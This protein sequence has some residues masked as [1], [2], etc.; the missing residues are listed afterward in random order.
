MVG[1]IAGYNSRSQIA[2]SGWATTNNQFSIS[3][4][5]V[6]QLEA[7]FRSD[8]Q[9]QYLQT[10]LLRTG[11]FVQ[12]NSQ[13]SVGGGYC[14]TDNRRTI[15]G[16]TGYAA[17]HQALEQAWYIHP[18]YFGTE[19]H[20]HKTFMRHRLRLENRWLPNL[21]E[22][23]DDLKKT[24]TSFSNRLRYQ[25]REQIPLVSFVNDFNKG[26]Y[27]LL[28]NEFFF[29]VSG[30]QYV[31][32]KWF[33]QNRSLVGAGYRFN[34]HIDLELSYMLRLIKDAAAGWSHENLVQVTA[35]SRL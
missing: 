16:T 6:Y 15:S 34:R 20:R 31:N 24:G 25:L 32:G 11:A 22:G 10:F 14:L 13:W 21:V 7:S 26:T 5:V 1:M 3:R 29:N 23:N 4:K 12:L 30:R 9:R 8:P 28:Q 17:E 2:L 35:F 33:D 18:V 19:G 27:V